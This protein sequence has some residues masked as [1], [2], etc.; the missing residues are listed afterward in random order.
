[1]VERRFDFF[2]G[3]VGYDCVV[4]C[5]KRKSLTDLF[6]FCSSTDIYQLVIMF[7]VLT[8]DSH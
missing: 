7:N 3:R 1:M 2:P 6:P 4:A 5:S 8:N